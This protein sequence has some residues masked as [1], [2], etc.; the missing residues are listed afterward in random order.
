MQWNQ[1]AVHLL[2]MQIAMV[3]VTVHSIGYHSYLQHL[4]ISACTVGVLIPAPAY[5]LAMPSIYGINP[6]N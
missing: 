5:W 4:H 3:T 6:G 1:I 2:L